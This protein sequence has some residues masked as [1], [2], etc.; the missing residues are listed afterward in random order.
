M[1]V[2]VFMSSSVA[3]AEGGDKERAGRGGREKQS[4]EVYSPAPFV[5]A[6][7]SLCSESTGH[8]HDHGRLGLAHLSVAWGKNKTH[9]AIRFHTAAEHGRI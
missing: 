6:V 7:F 2:G 5:L 1:C 9:T 8:D 4:L 3:H